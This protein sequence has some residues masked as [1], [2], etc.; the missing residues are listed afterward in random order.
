MPPI[1]VCKAFYHAFYQDNE[2]SSPLFP[3][4]LGDTYDTDQWEVL[5][6][7][8]IEVISWAFVIIFT[9]SMA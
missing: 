9:E 5:I 2:V 8:L 1:S 4:F 6:Y 7:V 3:H